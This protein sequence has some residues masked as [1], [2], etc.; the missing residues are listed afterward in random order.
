VSAIPRDG[1]MV[2]GNFRLDALQNAASV[3]KRWSA[4]CDTAAIA[5]SLNQT[6]MPAVY[7]TLVSEVKKY[8][9]Q[10]IADRMR[11]R[12]EHRVCS[13][14]VRLPV[15]M[16]SIWAVSMYSHIEGL[17]AARSTVEAGCTRMV[18]AGHLKHL[19]TLVQ[20]HVSDKLNATKLLKGYFTDFPEVMVCMSTLAVYFGCHPYDMF[21]MEFTP[22][23]TTRKGIQHFER[24]TSNS[25]ALQRILEYRQ[26]QISRGAYNQSTDLRTAYPLQA[27]APSVEIPLKIMLELGP[28][29]SPS[30]SAPSASSSSASSSSV[31][32]SSSS[33]SSSSVSLSS[34]PSQM[35]T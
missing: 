16:G 18:D 17:F 25:L 26:A 29:P 10:R 9:T 34:S 14:W 21:A 28:S 22:R 31:S 23:A 27:S 3:H 32:S 7:T 35:P 30:A 20:A 24:Y 19:A 15:F 8:C 2:K 12:R 6:T 13:A 11:V 1:H 5:R 4:Q 33:S